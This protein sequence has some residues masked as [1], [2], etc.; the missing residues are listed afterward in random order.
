MA[1]KPLAART[2]YIVE[3][4]TAAWNRICTHTQASKEHDKI[5]PFF[6][7]FELC[8]CQLWCMSKADAWL[9]WGTC[10][11]LYLKLNMDDTVCHYFSNNKVCLKVRSQNCPVVCLLSNWI[12]I[13]P[14]LDLQSVLWQKQAYAHTKSSCLAVSIAALQR[15]CRT[16][17]IASWASRQ[18]CWCFQLHIITWLQ[19]S[20]HH[21]YTWRTCSMLDVIA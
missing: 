19:S 9:N 5:T 16:F 14:L 3:H 6:L 15:L 12:W 20:W 18:A 17:L 4:R 11:T 8:S 2:Q 7:Q 1:S 21:H 10:Y 13:L